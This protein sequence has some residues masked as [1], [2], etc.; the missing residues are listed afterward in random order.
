MVDDLVDR[1]DDERKLVGMQADLLGAIISGMKERGTNHL[2]VP[3]VG[4]APKPPRC[5][6]YGRPM[7]LVRKN[8]TIWRTT[9]S[10][11]LRVPSLW[12]GRRRSRSKP[13]G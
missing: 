9:R 13:A 7:Q 12:R 5:F 6:G 10:V 1:T 8:A 4:T 2:Y 11:H 3:S